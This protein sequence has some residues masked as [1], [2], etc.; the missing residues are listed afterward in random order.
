MSW[1]MMLSMLIM[2]LMIKTFTA[3][4]VAEALLL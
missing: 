1:L 4:D 3:L 2:K